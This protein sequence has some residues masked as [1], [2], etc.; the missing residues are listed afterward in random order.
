M[1]GVGKAGY[2]TPIHLCL[3]YV[4]V[5]EAPS[6]RTISGAKMDALALQRVADSISDFVR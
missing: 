3:T 2:L 5:C 1:L 4:G 6:A